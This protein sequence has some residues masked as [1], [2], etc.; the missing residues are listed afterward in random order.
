MNKR[1]GETLGPYEERRLRTRNKLRA[2]LER[3][4][5]GRPIDPTL[6]KI[7]YRL[8]V[9]T[10]ARE[11]SVGRNAIYTNHRALVEE[12]RHAT[13]QDGQISRGST[14]NKLDEQRA[15]IDVMKV[16]ER[17]MITENAVLLKRALD[18]EAEAARHRK[19]NA[20]LI[21]ERDAALRP[22]PIASKRR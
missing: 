8:T 14:K 3:L 20:R 19:H 12:L 22:V 4:V 18:A 11:A 10:L 21:A 13:L 6:R 16:A 7:R 2:A 17:R 15:A 9:S 1:G 5:A